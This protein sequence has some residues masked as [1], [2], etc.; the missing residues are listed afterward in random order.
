[1]NKK[2]I[3][4]NWKMN[5]SLRANAELLHALSTGEWP[6]Q[7]EV[8]VCAPAVY[9]G[10]CQALL[11]EAG[12]M[13]YGAQ[14]VSA[15]E[16]GAYTGE[17]SAAMLR[18]FGV[19]YVIVGHSERRQYHHETDAL[20]ATK[21]QR[22]LA[23]GIVPI[24]CVGETLAQREA[25]TTDDVVCSQFAVVADVL[26]PQVADIVIAYEPVWAIG[27]GRTA[28]PEQ[29]QQ[30]HALLRQELGVRGAAS[31]RVLYGGSMNAA[32]AASLLAQPDIDGGLIG[33]A[34]LKAADFLRI[35]AS[36]AG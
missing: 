18:E 4:G 27:T 11:A 36:V 24:V 28:T 31:V 20:V 32:N 14:D 21:A 1:M 33:G 5:G 34:S 6:S 23:Q 25:G 10:Q 17:V 2:L 35:A 8:A 7:C 3:A 22:A 30:V 26:G 16:A 9:L 13:A 19:R 29:A 15:H 12:K